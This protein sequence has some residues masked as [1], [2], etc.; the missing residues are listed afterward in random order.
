M[1]HIKWDIKL[2]KSLKRRMQ[3]VTQKYWSSHNCAAHVTVQVTDVHKWVSPKR[4]RFE[5]LWVASK[6]CRSWGATVYWNIEGLQW[7]SS[8]KSTWNSYSTS[9]L[10]ESVTFAFVSSSPSTLYLSN[11]WQFIY[12]SLF[13]SDHKIAF[14]ILT[15]LL[16]V[17]FVLSTI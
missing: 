17:E 2:P 16:L 6:R 15:L 12:F 1:T 14:E 13:S 9:L 7:Q 3:T 4:R 10:Y 8:V 5:V 11:K